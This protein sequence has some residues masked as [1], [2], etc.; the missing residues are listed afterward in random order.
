MNFFMIGQIFSV[1][2]S[3]FLIIS[4]LKKDS[5][6]V[7]K[8]QVFDSFFNM[9]SSLF[10]YGYMGAIMNGWAFIRNI[11]FLKNKLSNKIIIIVLIIIGILTFITN[12]EG[13]VG[14]IP[15]LA[16]AEYSIALN[17]KEIST[18]YI[19]FA[20]LINIFLWL[21]Y[22]ILIVS[23]PYIITNIFLIILTIIEIRKD[24]KNE[25]V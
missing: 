6:S 11:I 16:S 21:I 9:I 4:I 15:F 2:G 20:L 14:Y 19:K 7:I 10:L 24:D 12:K 25:S 5:N 17:K 18:K 22:M 8:Y 3:I 1:I 23:I 13:W